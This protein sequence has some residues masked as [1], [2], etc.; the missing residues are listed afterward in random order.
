MALTRGINTTNKCNKG[1]SY[2]LIED[3]IE[4]SE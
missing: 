1:W 2:L 3:A 4:G